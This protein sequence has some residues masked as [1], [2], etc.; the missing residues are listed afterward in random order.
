[1]DAES[2]QQLWTSSHDEPSAL[3]HRSLQDLVA[4]DVAALGAPYG[5]IFEAELAAARSPPHTLQLRDCLVKYYEY[6][7]RINAHTFAD[8]LLCFQ[9]VRE[10]NPR[11]AEAWAGQAMLHLDSYAY[12][13]GPGG[14]EALDDARDATAKALSLDSDDFLGNLAQARVYFYDGDP[15]LRAGLE[16]TLALRPASGDRLGRFRGRA[17]VDRASTRSV[18]DLEG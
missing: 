9:T 13:F 15:R 5:P 1:M 14:A 11:A 4:R 7:R 3:D 6:R 10:R 17:A 2:G 16:R 12:R 8:A 18:A